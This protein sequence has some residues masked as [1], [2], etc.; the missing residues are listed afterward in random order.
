MLREHL[1]QNATPETSEALRNPDDRD[2]PFS[3]G[4]E[5]SP[6]S[7]RGHTITQIPPDK[8]SA[9]GP[10]TFPQSPLNLPPTT[11]PLFITLSLPTPQVEVPCSTRS[12]AST[13]NQRTAY[14]TQGH[15]NC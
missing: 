2:T 15:N 12:H 3:S 10:P 11:P 5:R 8:P 4:E 6:C 14:Y 9:H 7:R 1:C 13:Q